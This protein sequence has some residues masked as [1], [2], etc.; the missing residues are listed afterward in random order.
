MREDVSDYMASKQLVDSDR[1]LDEERK[2][3]RTLN[4][5]DDLKLSSKIVKLERETPNT[6][7]GI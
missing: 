4:D 1:R 2:K 3:L 7:I 6:A 5:L